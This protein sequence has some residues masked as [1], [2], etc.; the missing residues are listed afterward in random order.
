LTKPWK[1]SLNKNT[2]QKGEK[3][4][5]R[6][7]E[8]TQGVLSRRANPKFKGKKNSIICL[9]SHYF[10]LTASAHCP[11]P[12]EATFQTKVYIYIYY[13]AFRLDIRDSSVEST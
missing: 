7:R 12:K 5:Q 8:R 11:Q 6:E 2:Q 4:E 9:I 1:T 10:L 3:K 13:G